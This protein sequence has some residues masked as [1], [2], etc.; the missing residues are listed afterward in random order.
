M[1]RRWLLIILFFTPLVVWAC[2][3]PTQAISSVPGV[4]CVTA[5]VCTNDLVHSREAE[6][7]YDEAFNFVSS[8]LGPMGAKPIVVFCST[9]FCF[10]SFG[11]S[12]ATAKSIGKFCIVIGPRGWKPY[13]VR[14]EMIHYLQSDKLGVIKLMMT[15]TWFTEGM[16]YKLS[17]DPR[18]KLAEPWQQYRT[19]FDLWYRAIDKKNLWDEAR[20]L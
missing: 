4:S 18:A 1:L 7:L 3:M 16:A 10:Q 11:P 9:Q 2:F 12:A 5:T 15:P 19:H 14:H 20:K 8:T 6:E 17:E 13:Y